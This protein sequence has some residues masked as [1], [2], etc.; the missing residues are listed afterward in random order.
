MGDKPF[1]HW[2]VAECPS[3]DRRG[4]SRR[5]LAKLGPAAG[6]RHRTERWMARRRW[7]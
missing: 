2:M 7:A 3:A 5:T 1:V 4:A 6:L